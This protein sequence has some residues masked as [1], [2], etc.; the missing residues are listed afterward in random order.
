MIDPSITFFPVGNGDTSL[1]R[2]SNGFDILIDCNI[3]NDSRDESD[4]TTYDVH[5][6]LLSVLKSEKE[7]PF[8][9]AFILTHPDEDHCRGF[10]ETFYIGDPSEYSDKDKKAGLIRI[11]ELWFTPR[12][13]SPHEKDMCD[14]AKAIRKEAKRR[15]RLYQDKK[16]ERNNSGNRLQ[17]IGY[18]DNSDL[19]GLDEIITSPG[20]SISSINGSTLKDFSFFV[21]APFKK[22]TDS[23]WGERNDTSVVLQARFDVEEEKNAALAFFGGDSGFEI[24]E[25]IVQR[26]KEATL[27]WDIFMSPHHCSWSFFNTVP[28]EKDDK[29][30]KPSLEFLNKKCSGAVI[31][32]SCKP[33][34][35]DDDN[36]PHY[37]A[38][39]QYKK[40]VGKENFYVTGEYPNSK[41]PQPLIFT[42]TKK[43]LQRKELSRTQSSNATSAINTVLKTP[44]TY[45]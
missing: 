40:I 34:K 37:A 43:G 1:I 12:I 39:E 5:N 31:V 32:A 18:S 2:L 8:V 25:D 21:H 22:D 16:S 23:K 38:A 11:Y 19:K 14:T 10:S 27:K 44:H 45:G 6:H 3:T 42:I 15:M 36:P 4:D 35:N 28:Y 9:D 41:K 30:C 26:S 29:P 13:F 17:I 20:D 24:W 7:I 33:I